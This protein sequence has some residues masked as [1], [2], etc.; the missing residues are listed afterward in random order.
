VRFRF[1]RRVV[2]AACLALAA[3]CPPSAIAA[4]P[5][6]LGFYDAA[7]SGP[8][9]ATWLK[10]SVQA[11]ADVAR[12]DIGWDAPDTTTRPPGFNARNPADPH[13]DF[14]AADQEIRDARA[15]GLR[16]LA[17]FTGAPPWA[18]GPDMP[19]GT[20]PGTWRPSPQALEDY[21]IALGRRYSGHFPDPL[22]PG[23]TLPRVA[24]FQLWNEPNLSDYLT[25]QWSG[26]QPASP[27]WYRLMLNAFYKGIKSVDPSAL[28][29]TAGTAPFGDFESGG[30]RMLPVVFWQ[31]LLCLREVA[32]ALHGTGCTDPAH[33]DVMAHHP[34]SVG[35]PDT[36]ALVAGD[37]SIPD[38]GKLTRLLRAAERTGGALPHIHH[39]LWVTEVGYNTR[40]PNPKGVPMAKDARWVEWALEL[41]WS[42]GVD[43]ITWNTIVD[44]PPIPSYYT[45]SQS[46]MFFLDG[47]PKPTLIAFRFPLVAWRA[48]GGAIRV[49]GRVPVSGQLMIERRS[50]S[51]WKVVRTLAA[52]AGSTFFTLVD[53]PGTTT[54]RAQIRGE[55]SLPWPL[56]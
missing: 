49:W 21:G 27:V 12:I 42:E 30:L 15:D 1:V 51:A 53:S 52:S 7:F 24:A 40:P 50:G 38:L 46:G 9:A 22:H 25:P 18:E 55:T 48:A 29:V 43:L 35:P 11:G 34:Y 26:N 33:F 3:L 45:T 32:G 47:R 13:Y 8:Q 6:E 36:R 16:I 41:L 20:Q 5:L 37:V 31:N 19:A 23:Q 2:L 10:R 17:T 39:Q 54:L 56:A 4:R 44:Q 14:T 28:V